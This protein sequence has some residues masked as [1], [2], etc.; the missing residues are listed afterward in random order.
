MHGFLLWHSCYFWDCPSTLPK[1]SQPTASIWL[2]QWDAYWSSISHDVSVFVGFISHHTAFTKRWSS[3][4]PGLAEMMHEGVTWKGPESRLPKL[5]CLFLPLGNEK[6]QLLRSEKFFSEILVFT[7]TAFCIGKI[8]SDWPSLALPGWKAPTA[9]PT[10]ARSTWHHLNADRL[11]K[12][13]AELHALYSLLPMSPLHFSMP[14]K[15]IWEPK[16][17]YT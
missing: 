3:G 13:S 7:E 17:S 5:Y 16:L 12:Q 14:L 11:L 15:T 10:G 4:E 9:L 1:T 6:I 8:S 2:V